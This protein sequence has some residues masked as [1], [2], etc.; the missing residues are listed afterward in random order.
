M[1]TRL[2]T[3]LPQIYKALAAAATAGSAAYAG[4]VDGGVSADEWIVVGAAAVAAGV[5]V[6]LTP[7]NKEPA[8]G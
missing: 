7:K 3:Y 2:V 1:F 6:W 5:A 8:A 4:A